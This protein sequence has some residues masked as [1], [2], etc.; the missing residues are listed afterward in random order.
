MPRKIFKFLFMVL[1][2][3][4]LLCL[5]AFLFAIWMIAGVITHRI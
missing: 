2:V 1:G 4:E 3:H 5:A